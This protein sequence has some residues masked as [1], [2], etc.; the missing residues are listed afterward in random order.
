MKLAPLAALL[1]L[2]VVATAC[3]PRSGDLPART[4][5]FVVD[6]PAM[7]SFSTVPARPSLRDNR[8]LARD[9]LDLTFELENG[10]KVPR[11]TRFDGEIAVSLRGTTTPVLRR[12]L[13]RL[14]RRLRQEAKVPVRMARNGEPPSLIVEVISR[15]D[16]QRAV[17]TAACF[18]VP[19]VAGWQAFLKSRRSAAT[20][21]TTL[22][23]REVV[24]VFLPGDVSPQ[25]AR[26][27]LHEEIAQA[28]GPLNDL[29]R[30]PDSV[31][32]D[33]NFHTVLTGFDMLMLR[34]TY[35]DALRNGMSRQA[36]AERLPAILARLNPAGEQR[37]TARTIRSTRAWRDAIAAAL[38]TRGRDA[39]R[40]AAAQRA[41]R[42]A[43]AAGWDDTRTGFSYYALGRLQLDT[44][45]EKALDSFLNA[46]RIYQAAPDTRIQEAHVGARLA[47]F[48]LGAG[49]P[50][51]ALALVADNRGA[52]VASENAALLATLLM[53]KSDALAQQGNLAGA[54]R[55]RT[56]ALGWARYGFGTATVLQARS[57]ELATLAPAAPEG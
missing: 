46:A 19:R 53:L 22:Q 9:F 13:D 4:E 44:A 14:L 28:L 3:A 31:F 20:D 1:L 35:D 15:R 45:P 8:Q 43:E 49:Q 11:L 21:W 34:V 33:D 7:R 26:D 42:L 18:V 48:A 30:L 52:A 16:L 51:T 27:C 57:S 2:V 37:S 50:E 47:G 10:T 17:P 55:Q 24:S 29:Y 38:R 23:R 54:E 25:E 32:N 41:V 12:D 36:A 56:E 40:L 39:T 6:L 5:T